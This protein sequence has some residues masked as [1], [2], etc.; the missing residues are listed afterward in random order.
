ML[1]VSDAGSIAYPHG[2]YE[3]WSL[4]LHQ[5]QKTMFQRDYNHK[6]TKLLEKNK[7]GEPPLDFKVCNNF[8]NKTENSKHKGDIYKSDHS[9]IKNSVNRE[10]TV[11]LIC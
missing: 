6:D 5:T 10:V 7:T 8:L 9:K 3:T 11:T 2:K 1:S 4:P